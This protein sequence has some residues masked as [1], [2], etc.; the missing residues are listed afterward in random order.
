M[1]Q[2]R[3][4]QAYQNTSI[5]TS[6][7]QKLIVML[8]DGMNR[9]MSQAIKAIEKEELET[10]HNHLTRVGK[11]LMELLGTLREDV[12]GD[13][14]QNLKKLYVY[15]Y[16]K[17]VV[18]N[19]TKDV[20]AIREVQGILNNLRQGWEKTGKTQVRKDVQAAAPQ[21]VSITG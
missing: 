1:A 3:P 19:L 6:N 10:A 20:Q 14:A 7:Q 9:F 12:G 2:G 16:E 8:Y 15:S 13:I 4:Y 18:A 21:R 5:T 17:I 11:I